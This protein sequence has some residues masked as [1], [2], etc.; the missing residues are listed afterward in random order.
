MGEVLQRVM[1]PGDRCAGVA[2]A[3]GSAGTIAAGDWVKQRH[4]GAKISASEAL[5]CP[6]LLCAGFGSHRIEG[7]GDKH[8]PWVHNVRNTDLIVAV[9][10]AAPMAL[11]RLFNEEA[12]KAYLVKAGVPESLV[13]DLPLL[14][15]S[16]ISNVVSAVKMARWYELGPRDVV[17]TV[18]TD[19][20]DLYA[21]RV[22]E[23]REEQGPFDAT[24]AAVAHHRWMLGA[25]TDNMAELGH[26]DRKRVHNLKYFTWV[27]Q[28]GKTAE[29]L[30][31]LWDPAWWE[32]IQA[33]APE[34]DR[35][36]EEFN[37]AVAAG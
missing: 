10:D 26:R 34:I 18:L 1:R 5:Q 27:E 16:G 15:I 9:D 30:D 11:L 29:E 12:G 8:V 14:G 25:S 2:S 13:R 31:A 21:S 20:M 37:G 33:Q 4:P 7:I 28:Q 35:L 19:S 17:V 32:A 22:A 23:L 6:T 3:T 36:I 24:A